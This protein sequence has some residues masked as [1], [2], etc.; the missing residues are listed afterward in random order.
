MEDFERKH[1]QKWLES[2]YPP[3]DHE[4]FL[5]EAIAFRREDSEEFDYLNTYRGWPGIAGRLNWT[6]KSIENE[7]LRDELL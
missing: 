5:N 7:K 4:Q 2:Q 6:E 1:L 3:E